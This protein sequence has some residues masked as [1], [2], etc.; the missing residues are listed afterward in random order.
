[1]LSKICV[2]PSTRSGLSI[3]PK[4]CQF[5]QHSAN[6]LGHAVPSEGMAVAERHTKQVRIYFVQSNQTEFRTFLG[7]VDC[8]RRLVFKAL[9]KSQARH[10]N[11]QRDERKRFSSEKKSTMKPFNHRSKHA[12][13]QR[14][15]R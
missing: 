5:L 4:N 3:D 8:C 13:L 11:S 9:L 6:P 15:H 14:F 1:M 10:I 7:L 12:A 2:G